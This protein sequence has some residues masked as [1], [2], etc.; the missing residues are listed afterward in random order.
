MNKYY[1]KY[2]KDIS[3]PRG[4]IYIDRLDEYD[5][6]LAK[7]RRK[8]EKMHNQLLTL[9]QLPWRSLIGR[10]LYTLGTCYHVIGVMESRGTVFVV[11]CTLK[12]VYEDTDI[13]EIP[14][15]ALPM[16][17]IETPEGYVSVK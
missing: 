6:R 4:N 7:V 10:D 15:D 2:F 16:Y 14:K 1:R 11:P 9:R 17:L 13:I 8:I 5:R 3:D 12:D